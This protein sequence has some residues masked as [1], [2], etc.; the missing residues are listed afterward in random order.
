METELRNIPEHVAIIMDGNGR[1]A[2]KLGQ[3]RI[4]GH[5]EGMENVRRIALKANEC[6]VKH[7]TLFAFSTENW[8]RPSKEVSFLMK[9]PGNFLSKF[10]PELIENNVVIKTIGDFVKL[11]KHTQKAVSKAIEETRDNTGMELIFALNYGS[12]DEIVTTTK[13][14][15]ERVLCGEIAVE[16]INKDLFSAHLSTKGIPDPEV[17][18]RT[19]GEHRISNFL[20]WQISYSEL[21]FVKQSWPEFTEENFE[22]ILYDYTHRERRF[23]GLKGDKDEN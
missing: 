7:L 14:I 5:Q 2:K 11:P 1:Y 12:R 17:L 22:Q 16:D 3:P 15:V 20:L 21:F 10:L 19:S 13:T 4:K 18:I 8:T 9:L 6:G 23:G